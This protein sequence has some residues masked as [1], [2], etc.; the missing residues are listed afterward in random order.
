MRASWRE[1]GTHTA[2]NCAP[3]AGFRRERAATSSASDKLS[4]TRRQARASTVPVSGTRSDQPPEA[5]PLSA[6]NLKVAWRS[7]SACRMTT[8]SSSVTPTGACSTIVWL[9]W[10]TGPGTPCNQ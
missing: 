5:S 9:N 7:R 1:S 8:T 10:S 4:A 3:A 2:L 6:R